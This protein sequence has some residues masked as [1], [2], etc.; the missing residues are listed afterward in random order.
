MCFD[1]TLTNNFQYHMILTIPFN[2][3]KGKNVQFTDKY[4]KFGICSCDNFSK[5]E[6]F[7]ELYARENI[8][9]HKNIRFIDV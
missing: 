9:I 4:K 5:F 2:E 1:V 3:I 6:V 8:I 7:L